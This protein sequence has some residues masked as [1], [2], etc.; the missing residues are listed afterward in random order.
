M[1]ASA[2]TRPSSANV[3]SAA[4][5]ANLKLLEIREKVEAIIYS[6]KNNPYGFTYN[7][8]LLGTTEGKFLL[9]NKASRRA[10]QEIKDLLNSADF[11][12]PARGSQVQ[13]LCD[14]CKEPFS[15]S[16]RDVSATSPPAQGA[17]SSEMAQIFCS[18]C[19]EAPASSLDLS[20]KAITRG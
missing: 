1:S 6:L 12:Q 5:Q 13:L 9:G 18:R 20:E 19:K 8:T 17:V 3:P 10:L 4:Q 16:Q 7:P 11:S 15:L 14:G 2:I